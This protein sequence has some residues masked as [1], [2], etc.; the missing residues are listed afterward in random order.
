MPQLTSHLRRRYLA[1]VPLLLFALVAC[2]LAVAL[3][4]GQPNIHTEPERPDIVWADVSNIPLDYP[5]SPEEQA[6]RKLA[7]ERRDSSLLPVC[8]DDYVE[9]RSASEEARRAENDLM[10][11]GVDFWSAPGCRARVDRYVVAPRR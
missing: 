3:L 7:I 4:D 10:P 11:S 6:M 1:A 5:W 9:W 8:T 2:L